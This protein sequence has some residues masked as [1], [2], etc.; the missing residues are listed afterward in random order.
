MQNIFCEI[1]LRTLIELFSHQSG[2][3]G[4]KKPHEGEEEILVMHVKATKYMSWMTYSMQGILHY[5]A[6]LSYFPALRLDMGSELLHLICATTY[7]RVYCI[8]L[9]LPGWAKE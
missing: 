9:G 6:L 7:Y 5:L 1:I 2:R 4:L 3:G 8:V